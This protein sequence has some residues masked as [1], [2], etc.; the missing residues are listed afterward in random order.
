[1]KTE[2]DAFFSQSCT[3]LDLPFNKIKAFADALTGQRPEFREKDG[4]DWRVGVMAVA[5]RRAIIYRITAAEL[6]KPEANIRLACEMIRMNFDSLYR[7][8]EQNRL[9][10]AFDSYLDGWRRREDWFHIYQRKL[11]S[12]SSITESS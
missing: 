12:C 8:S 5:E 4:K 9:T 11:A 1:M 3:D 10:L 6:R 7:E 2:Y